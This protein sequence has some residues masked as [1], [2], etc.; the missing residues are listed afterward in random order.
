MVKMTRRQPFSLVY[1]PVVHQ[2]LR[3]IDAKYFSLIR[4]TVEYGAD[5][6]EKID[7][8]VCLPSADTLEAW[9]DRTG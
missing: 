4:S 7:R 9:M 8:A 2:H 3:A 5:L 1:A 6:F